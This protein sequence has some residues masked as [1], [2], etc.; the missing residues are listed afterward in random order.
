MSNKLT[1]VKARKYLI[2]LNKGYHEVSSY[3]KRQIKNYIQSRH[4]IPVGSFDMIKLKKQKQKTPIRRLSDK[5]LNELTLIEIKSSDRNLNENLD[6][7]FFGYSYSEQL[8]AQA[9][10]NRYQF[11]FVVLPRSGGRKFHK[12]MTYRQIWK[13]AKTIHMQWSIKF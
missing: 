12:V 4:P 7:Y 3:A 10:G 1:A 13:K 5:E 11:A 6:G 8:V 9:L 2:D